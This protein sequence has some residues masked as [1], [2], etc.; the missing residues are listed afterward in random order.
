MLFFLTISLPSCWM[1][2][3]YSVITGSNG[4]VNYIQMFSSKSTSESCE[5]NLQIK[6]K[7]W[8]KPTLRLWNISADTKL[9]FYLFKKYKTIKIL[10]RNQTSLQ[11]R[12][13]LFIV[14]RAYLVL[15][16]LSCIYLD[17]TPG[18]LSPA[19]L[20]PSLTGTSLAN[21]KK[22]YCQYYYW[23]IITAFKIAK[24][25]NKLLQRCL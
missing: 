9:I 17:N 10:K 21:H 25:S 19:S 20:L 2:Y 13:V 18:T 1:G 4:L 16:R 12:N 11:F 23:F 14:S 24:K 3:D 15:C 6:I 5:L 22:I 7:L 8:L